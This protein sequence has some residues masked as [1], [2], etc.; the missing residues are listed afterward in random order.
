MN[1]L[2]V[3]DDKFSQK[4]IG[5]TFSE[6]FTTHY[7]SDGIEGLEK[8]QLLKPDIAIL[9][10][11][12]P[13]LNGYEVCIQLKQNPETQHIP[14]VFLSG[15]NTLR[16][17]MQGYEVGGDD[18]LVKP[19]EPESLSAKIKVLLK[20][21]DQHKELRE[22]YEIA[23][24]TAHIAMTGSNELGQAMMFIEKSFIIHDYEELA[25]ALFEMT[26]R[27]G[28][29]ATLMFVT[30]DTE[31]L[32]YSSAGAV[33][34]LETQV[35]S[36]IHDEK[37]IYD[38]GCRT[39]ISFPNVSILIKN[40]PID[41]MESYGR[42]KDLFP[43]ILGAMNGKILTLNTE[44]AIQQ[45]STELSNSN[46]RIKSSLLEVSSFMSE[47]QNRITEVMR[48]M[49][50]E[51]SIRLPSLGLEEDQEEYILDRID[52]AIT[53]SMQ[54]VNSANSIKSIFSTVVNELTHLS[55]RQN[56]II[57]E[58]YEKTNKLREQK[59]SHDNDYSMDVELF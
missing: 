42:I 3:D 43:I 35:L 56:Q 4:I 59:D 28:L 44:H 36:M 9:D 5:K 2:I 21:Y 1:I 16:D 22:Q 6:E 33:S 34:P 51:L 24:K 37:R 11:E 8:A 12:M 15:N 23:Q 54:L 57:A 7:A 32:W 14:V 17:K 46:Q 13:G 26:D 10:V 19:F 38:F 31:P 41:D 49:L 39:V 29:T 25:N 18:Y 40:M 47:N 48:A 20:Y 55:E 50:E 53:D 52:Q 30:E 58:M 27:L 45:Q